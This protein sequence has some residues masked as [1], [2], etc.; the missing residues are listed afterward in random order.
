MTIVTWHKSQNMELKT[1][2]KQLGNTDIYLIDQILKERYNGTNKILDAGSGNGRNLQW[3]YNN[4]NNIWAVDKLKESVEHI[5]KRY[6]LISDNCIK[7]NLQNLPFENNLFDHIIC[8][9]VLHFAKNKNDFM[10]MFHELIRVLKPN[11][12]LFI[13]TA[14][15]ISIENKISHIGNHIYKLGDNTEGFLI[16][17]DDINDLI[18]SYSLNLLEPIKTVNVNDMRAMTTLVLRKN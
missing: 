13:R 16:N 2:Q 8:C 6:S 18:N 5:K 15:T 1:L 4:K 9:A 12:T 14:S 10:M 7:C 11:G 17:K 3:F